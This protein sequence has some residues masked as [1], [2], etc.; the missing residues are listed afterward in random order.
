MRLGEVGA[1]VGWGLG[2]GGEGDSGLGEGWVRVP[3]A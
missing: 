1:R 3:S 2:E